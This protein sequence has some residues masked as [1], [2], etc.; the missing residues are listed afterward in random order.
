MPTHTNI[1]KYKY[2][3]TKIDDTEAIITWK[4]HKLTSKPTSEKSEEQKQTMRQAN[5]YLRRQ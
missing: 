2:I 5:M 4:S 3:E 1:N